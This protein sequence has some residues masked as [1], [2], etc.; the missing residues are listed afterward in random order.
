MEAV[1][2]FIQAAH[3]GPIKIG[4][5]NSEDGAQKRLESLQTGSPYPLVLCRVMF[6]NHEYK[7]HS[8]FAKHRLMGEWFTPIKELALLANGK[9]EDEGEELASVQDAFSAGY[10]QGQRDC[11]EGWQ[12]HLGFWLKAL[13]RQVDEM[14]LWLEPTEESVYHD[15]AALGFKEYVARK[16]VVFGSQ[17]A[18]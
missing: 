18:A 1:T 4:K 15:P 8:R 12:E 11:D 17:R 6:G 7:L 13:G 10:R 2:Y 5:S 16:R 9:A 3:G 14:T